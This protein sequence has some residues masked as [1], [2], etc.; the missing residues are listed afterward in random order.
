MADR[1]N[2][3][4][5][6]FDSRDHLIDTI[7]ASSFVPLLSGWLPPR[8]DG[9]L[10]FDGGYSDNVPLL[11]ANTLT[12][13]PFSGNQDICPLDDDDA[14]MGEVLN[15]HLPTGP[16]TSVAVSREN[17]LRFRMAMLPP[18]PEEL[19]LVCRQG[20]ED[21]YRYLSERGIIQC[22]DCRA[23]KLKDGVPAS[24]ADL[25]RADSPENPCAGCEQLLLD[26]NHRRL[27]ADLG[28]IFAEAE[29]RV[30]QRQY[31]VVAR[32]SSLSLAPY[33]LSARLVGRTAWWMVSGL[34]PWEKTVRTLV[35]LSPALLASCPFHSL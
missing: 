23:E 6:R 25:R 16:T 7:L 12:V 35:S 15:L 28:E 26:D 4:V 27:P 14:G 32:L 31:G 19:L 18:T 30:R 11:D 17:L 20:F 13:S 10:V 24:P 9:E 33:T 5:S 34:L 22:V 3:I 21:A 2:R 29:A 8:L 1:T